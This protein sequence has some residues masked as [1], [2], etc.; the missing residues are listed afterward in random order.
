MATGISAKITKGGVSVLRLHYSA[1]P[2]KRPGT[3]AGDAWIIQQA[4]GYPGGTKSARWKKEMEID[5]GALGGTKALPEWENWVGAGRIVIP[6][7]DATGYKLYG[8]YDHGWRSPSAY[9]VHGIDGDGNIVTLWEFYADHVPV[10][11]ISDIIKGKSV[12]LPDGRHFQGNP[13]AGLEAQKIADPKI[14]A[15]DQAMSDNTMKSTCYLFEQQGVYF[16]PGERGGDTTVLE[17][18]LGYFWADPQNPRYRITNNCP[19]LIWELGKMRHRELSAKVAMNRDAPEELV[20]KDNH[21][22]DGLKMFLKLFPPKPYQ[23]K[24]SAKPA[25]FD[26]WRKL[27]KKEAGEVLPSY[28]REM[29]G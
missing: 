20:D 27:A 10:A 5:Y 9:H 23:V 28:R 24:S 19:K 8:S 16:E 29:A 12:T 17:W 6:P 4:A 26:W 21:A 25:T 2:G 15:E 3:E 14:W 18:L 22:W 11:L 1:D 7:F 13:F